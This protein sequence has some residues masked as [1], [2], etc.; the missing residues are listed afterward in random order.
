MKLARSISIII[1]S[2][3]TLFYSCERADPYIKVTEVSI[4]SATIAADEA[5]RLP[6]PILIR[7]E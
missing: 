3:L 5:L 6:P 7:V 1:L 2:L 4:D